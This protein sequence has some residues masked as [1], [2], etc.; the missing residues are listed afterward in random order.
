[1]IRTSMEAGYVQT[2]AKTTIAPRIY[3]FA[4]QSLT[5]AEVSTWLTFW[6]ARKG[7]GEAFDFTDPRTAGVVSC[8]FLNVQA[9][10]RRTGPVTYDIDVELEEAL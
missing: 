3:K 1:M 7:G 6:N 5:G 9:T 4:H 8:R 10:I 2:R